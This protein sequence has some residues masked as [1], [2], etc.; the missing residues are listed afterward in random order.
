MNAR[1]KQLVW[2]G[3]AAVI[4][5]TAIVRAWFTAQGVSIGLWGVEVCDHGCRGIRWDNVPGAQDDLYL[6][7]YAAFAAMLVGAGALVGVALGNPAAVRVARF[8][9]TLALA[10]M[11]FFIVRALILDGLDHVDIGW[12]LVVGPAATL[13]ARQL[14]PTSARA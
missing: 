4:A 1:T 13:A 5:L 6:M 8:A 11:A 12:A 10:A 7:A 3:L 9:L 2:V 14:L